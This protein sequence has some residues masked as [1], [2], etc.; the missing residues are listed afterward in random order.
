MAEPELSSSQITKHMF[1]EFIQNA[2]PNVH[3][4]QLRNLSNV[5]VS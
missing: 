1:F 2:L 4:R 3:D 5:L